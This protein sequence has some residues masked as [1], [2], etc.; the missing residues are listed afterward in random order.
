MRE[1][2]Q[3][4]LIGKTVRLWRSVK[5][6][7]VQLYAAN[8][9]YFIVMAVFP[10]LLLLLGLL[11]HTPLEVERLGEMLSGILPEPFL[12]GAEELI[13]TTY[14]KISGTVLGLSAVTALWSAGRGMYGVLTG[15]NAIYGVEEDR[16]Y[17][18][19]RLISVAY[20]LAFLV[21]LLLTLALHVF[22]TGL[23][24]LLKQASHPFLRFLVE[25]VDF[26]FFLLLFL[27][28]MIFTVMF[29]A[30]PNGTYRFRDSVPGA[31]LASCGWLVF[32][33]LFSYYVEHFAG[34]TNVYGSVYAL[35][36]GML[37]LYCCMSIVFYGGVLNVLLRKWR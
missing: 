18:K 37:W 17:L 28:T 31:L 15:L 20:T 16:G 23:L 14:D 32:S 3:G 24:G 21:V 25:F 5:Q 27:Q 29:M 35:A 34:L 13:L 6:L 2:P 8:A 11:Q 10:T 7:R 4:G 22:G 1:F 36:L 30:L 9:S 33:N 19:V 12:E 26:R